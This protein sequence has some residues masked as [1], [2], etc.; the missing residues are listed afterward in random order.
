MLCIATLHFWLLWREL[1]HGDN[2]YNFLHS[3]GRGHVCGNLSRRP[4]LIP[5]PVALFTLFLLTSPARAEELK[6]WF[7][8][9]FFHIGNGF[10]RCPV[11]R[12]PLLSEAEMR[13]ESHSRIERGTSC[14]MAGE[15][16]QPNAYLYDAGIADAIRERMGQDPALRDASVWITVKRRFVWAEGCVTQAGQAARIE[17]LLKQVPEVERVFVDVMTG[18]D[19]KPPYPVL[20]GK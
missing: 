18:S 3:F 2:T 17:D 14:W 6:N 19:E 11:P 16:A 12:G 9:P 15:C 7:G 8:D 1:G 13:A 10:P 5:G 4:H 20:E